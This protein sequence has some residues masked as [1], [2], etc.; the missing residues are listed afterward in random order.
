MK[1]YS[2]ILIP[3]ENIYRVI[4]PGNGPELRFAAQSDLQL[5]EVQDGDCLYAFKDLNRNGILDPYEDWRLTPE[6]RA[7]DLASRLSVEEM[8]GLMLYP[9]GEPSTDDGQ[10]CEKD[11][12]QIEKKHIRFLHGNR[13]TQQNAV[14]WHNN[15]QALA[16]KV[17]PY[18]IPVNLASDPRNTVAGGRFVMFENQDMSAWPGNL[19]LAATFN[20]EYALIHGQIVSREYRAMCITTALSPQVDLATEPRWSRFAGTFGE[21]SRLAG[22]MAAAYVHGFQS[23]WNGTG[24]EA[25]DLGW[26]PESVVT[27]I[28]H[29]PGDGAAEGGREAHNNF[30]KYNVYPGDNLQEHAAVFAAAFDIP[31]SRTGGAAAVM[32]SYSIAMTETGPIGEAVGSGYSSWKL[33]WLLQNRMGYR[34]TICADWDIT[35]D[36]KWGMENRT[37]LERHYQAI[38]AGLHM[39]GG[40]NDMEINRDA[41]FFGQMARRDYPNDI[42]IPA[43]FAALAAA[44]KQEEQ[45][46]RSPKEQMDSIYRTAAAHCL[47]MSFSCGLFENAYQLQ[48]DTDALL[49]S[50][51]KAPEAFEAQ[52]ASLVLLKN[53]VI[54]KWDGTRKIVYIPLRYM[55]AVKG[56]AG[57]TPAGISMPFAGCEKL[58]TYFQVVTDEIR[59]DACPDHLLESDIIRRTDFTDVDFALV[60]ADSPDGGCGY[61]ADRVNLDPEKGP[62]DNGYLPI[63]LQYRPYTADPAVCRKKP[64]G[65]DPNEENTWIAAGGARGTSRLYAGKTVETS[66]A[67][68]LDLILDTKAA[69]GKIPVVVYL[70]IAKPMCFYEFESAADTILAGFAVSDAAALEI[71]AGRYEPGGLLPCQMPADMET[72]ETQMEDVPFDMNCH[73]DTDGHV[74]DYGYGLNWS[75]IIADWRTEK[76]AGAH[77]RLV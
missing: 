6:E 4:N 18:G 36:K 5:L 43:E 52:L 54:R 57:V 7:Q 35:D 1:T 39:F 46:P 14:R 74:Y 10:L 37:R 25:E 41:F 70:N 67:A 72:V 8:A 19:G 28:K 20:P 22:D 32:P 55:P 61:D 34:G 42:P 13:S 66:N 73:V 29:F 44:W 16:E 76:Y 24:A 62:L 21:G 33:T 63:S 15:M 12:I 23:T 48:A 30:G 49:E 11:H 38:Q 26:G 71:L 58:E 17:D 59:P 53:H 65:L 45:D 27:M 40:C 47:Q 75:G 68:D 9:V 60:A 51:R 31:G 3:E 50:T 77:R 2:I 64:I 69:V 56:F